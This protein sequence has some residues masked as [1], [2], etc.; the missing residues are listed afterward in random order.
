MSFQP[1]VWLT[2]VRFTSRKIWI[3]SSI[4][5]SIIRFV[6]VLSDLDCARRGSNQFDSNRLS[7]SPAAAALPL[8]H[9]AATYL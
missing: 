7:V 6:E 3:N 8:A 1:I 9:I 2:L 4:I 5:S